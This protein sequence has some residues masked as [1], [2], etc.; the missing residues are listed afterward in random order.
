MVK[1]R[2]GSL[3]SMLLFAIIIIAIVSV[4]LSFWSLK[5]MQGGLKTH[6]TKKELEKG[7]VIFHSSEVSSSDSK[8]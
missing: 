6:E 3:T 5:D 1:I 8:S 7:R 2:Q 4:G